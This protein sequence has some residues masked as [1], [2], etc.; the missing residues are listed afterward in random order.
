MKRVWLSLFGAL[1]L[2]LLALPFAAAEAGEAHTF[3]MP[4]DLKWVEAEAFAGT[5][6]ERVV[7]QRSL[8][9]IGDRAFADAAAL[10]EVYIPDSVVYISGNAFQGAGQLTVFGIPGSYAHG[11]ARIHGYRF[12]AV[13]IWLHLDDLPASWAYIAG[14]SPERDAGSKPLK[15]ITFDAGRLGNEWASKRPQERPE[16]NPIDYRFP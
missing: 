11:W 3:N 16:L 6:E 14:L 13:D 10:T 8:R 5:A 12:V 2:M 15:G 7:F 4:S 9:G 1:V